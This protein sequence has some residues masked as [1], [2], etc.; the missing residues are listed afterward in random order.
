MRQKIQSVA[1]QNYSLHR[2]EWKKRIETVVRDG[3]EQSVEIKKID[4]LPL[5]GKQITD[6][7]EKSLSDIT[8]QLI[9]SLFLQVTT[10]ETGKLLEETFQTSVKSA[11]KK[12]HDEINVNA[13]DEELNKIL[14]KV[15]GRI[16]ER[17]IENIG[18]EADDELI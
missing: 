8:Y 10:D 4:K 11:L 14:R 13:E 2:K 1:S 7:L 9:D 3:F 5:V 17:I 6:T 16:L 12:E 15:L 18:E